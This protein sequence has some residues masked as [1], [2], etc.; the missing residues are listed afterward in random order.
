MNEVSEKEVFSARTSPGGE[1]RATPVRV[2]VVVPV[3]NR[4]GELRRLLEALSNQTFPRDEMEVLICDDG[5]TEDLTPVVAEFS[6]KLPLVH[7]RQKNLG[8]GAARNLGLTHARGEIIA[9]TDSDC[10]P[11]TTWLEEIVRPLADPSVGIV[12]GKIDYARAE[13]L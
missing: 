2:S 3:Y 10:I 8:P 9:L 7:L 11:C 5:S 13:H 12:G 1:S 4:C 6:D